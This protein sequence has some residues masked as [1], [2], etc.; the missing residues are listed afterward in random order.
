MFNWYLIAGW[1]K[2]STPGGVWL[3]FFCFDRPFGL[4]TKKNRMACSWR[5]GG[6]RSWWPERVRDPP[7]RPW[8]SP[9]WQEKTESIYF[10][11]LKDM[12]KRLSC[13]CKLIRNVMEKTKIQTNHVISF[14]PRRPLPALSGPLPPRRPP[15]G[16][17]VGGW[18]GLRRGLGREHFTPRPCRRIIDAK[19]LTPR[20]CS[21]MDMLA[22]AWRLIGNNC[23]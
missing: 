12:Q 10:G 7:P 21:W 14:P 11:M 6:W 1:I 4:W 19:H 2:K 23:E 17:D 9:A 15:G 13:K 5:C 8:F 16:G 18:K 20:P 3:G 22:Q